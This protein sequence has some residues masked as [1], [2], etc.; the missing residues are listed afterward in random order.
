MLM[1]DLLP[2]YNKI[3]CS[4][5]D[6]IQSNQNKKITEPGD[7]AIMLTCI[8]ATLFYCTPFFFYGPTKA[9]FIPV[10]ATQSAHKPHQADGRP[11]QHEPLKIK[12]VDSITDIQNGKQ[13]LLCLRFVYLCISRVSLFGFL[14]LNDEYI[15]L[16]AAD[17]Q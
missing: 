12:K 9:D 4:F 1:C 17:R 5:I 11:Q 6:I 13:A 2:G 15:L 7:A 16:I 3:L 14:L 10:F 8:L